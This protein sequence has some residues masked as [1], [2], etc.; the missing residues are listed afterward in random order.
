MAMES[1]SSHVEPVFFKNSEVPQ[2]NN[3][4]LNTWEICK[5]VSAIVDDP[6]PTPNPDNP[7][8]SLC[9]G[10]QRIGNLWRIY[11]VDAEAR[12]KLLSNGITL[13]GQQVTLMNKNPFTIP[14]FENV[15][16]TRLFIRNI[17]LS[18][19]NE[20]IEKKLKAIGVQFAGPLKYSRARTP[21]NKLTNF[22]TGDR[23]A[24]IMIPHEP[25]PK[26][27]EI[28]GFHASLYH[29]EQKQTKEDIECG[30][31]M[32]KGHLR[33]ECKNEV[34]CY[35]CRNTG[36]K[37][38]DE[39]CPKLQGFDDEEDDDDEGD[40]EDDDQSGSEENEEVYESIDEQGQDESNQRDES[41]EKNVSQMIDEA[42]TPK[43]HEQTLSFATPKISEGSQTLIPGFFSQSLQAGQPVNRSGSPAR[44]KMADRTPEDNGQNQKGKRK[45]KKKKLK[46]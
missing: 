13:R 29:R 18:Y 2:H 8:T 10:A 7:E 21:D 27:L 16:T 17:P 39:C 23:F 6:N 4:W 28:G 45:I 36:H 41:A 22:K 11:L 34:V 14:G 43:S 42:L 46:A 38:G 12:V 24:D 15:P 40:D 9:E 44:R 26:K 1:T 25:L 31:C 35:E 19:D 37:K 33:K 3:K 32:M 20:E 30:N 5:A